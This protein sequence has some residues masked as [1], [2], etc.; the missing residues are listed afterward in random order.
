MA[1]N[2]K[3][4]KLRMKS[5]QSTMQITKAMELVASSKL[6][7]AK[8]RADAS[9]PY[10]KVLHDTLTDIAGGNTDF[11]SPY[12][13]KGQ[14]PRWCYVVIAGDRGLAGGYN[15]NLFKTLESQVKDKEYDVLP[16]GKKAVEY[17]RHRGI[18]IVTEE[19]AEAADISVSDC[20]EI[21]K[22]LCSAYRAGEY[23]HMALCYTN[24][25]SMLSQKPGVTSMLPLED[26]KK[27]EKEQEVIRSLIL[28]EPDSESVFDAIVPEYLAGLIY[29]AMC[30]SVASELAA[31]RTAM[32][33]ASK[34]A[35]EMI[36]QLSLYYNR[37]RQASITQEI[38]EIV[39]GAEEP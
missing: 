34:N 29:G 9:R 7:K 3:A 12:T 16:I 27:E 5:I 36:E 8:E 13:K 33:A 2:M 26:F 25:I 39:A 17:C 38:T 37:A 28:Y 15:A 24:F 18:G 10:F 35:G 19:F 4:V 31:R 14:S 11:M 21:A 32:D 23:G 22:L 6:R 20:F 30:E 1:G